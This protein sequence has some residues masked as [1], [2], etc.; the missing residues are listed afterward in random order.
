MKSL[1]TIKVLIE[2]A[3]DRLCIKLNKT[4]FD[5]GFTSEILQ[6]VEEFK[7]VKSRIEKSGWKKIYEKIKSTKEEKIK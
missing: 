2:T 1:T 6:L 3:D 7:T 4:P 5:V